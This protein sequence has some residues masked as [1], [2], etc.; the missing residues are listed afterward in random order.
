MRV[1]R[2]DS[3][4]APAA[5]P[6]VRLNAD[7]QTAGVRAIGAAA[8]QLGEAGD[9]FGKIAAQ[10]QDREDADL[11]FRAQT[12]YGEAT[13]QFDTEAMAA[14]GQN[15]WGI[16]DKAKTAYDEASRKAGEIL[17]TPRQQRIFNHW[18]G[19]QQANSYDRLARHEAEQRRVSLED[20]TKA[21]LVVEIDAAVASNGDANA[22]GTA[23]DSVGKKIQVLGDLNGW[24][25][26]RREVEAGVLLSTMHGKI[27]DRLAD[28][29]PELAKKY[30]ADN[31]KEIR[32]DQLAA[33]EKTLRQ[34]G[35]SSVA[36]RFVDEAEKSGLGEAAALAKAHKEYEG[37]QEKAAVAEVEHRYQKRRQLREQSEQDAGD[38]V[39]RAVNDGMTVDDPRLASLVAKA[40]PK[41]IAGLRAGDA[42]TN[43]GV[44]ADLREKAKAGRLTLTEVRSNFGGLGD[45]ERKELIKMLTKTPDEL[46]RVRSTDSQIA[47][48]LRD[49]GITGDPAKN[50]EDEIRK[51]VDVEQ[52]RVG[53]ELN[54]E[55]VQGVIDY[56]LIHNDD[57]WPSRFYQIPEAERAE[58]EPEDY[59]SV[60]LADRGEITTQFEE[61]RG[62]KPTP[63]EITV[64]YKRKHG[65]K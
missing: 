57:F 29:N 22:V 51:A 13:R 18:L 65:V 21:S 49:A 37:E 6:T 59:G 63:G 12:A 52:T 38:K 23:R 30:F 62:R 64:I 46:A 31:V 7:Q 14:R 28:T 4:V 50:A 61:L 2:Y 41:F 9:N 43:W 16:K 5:A 15:A 33:A 24:D 58:E 10:M 47:R 53:S 19:Q 8:E 25:S 56:M 45:T 11:A 32:G 1:P 48:N 27:I 34:S 17:K 44:Y 26:K 40:D 36:Q 42:K 3:Q 60:P 54:S 35:L 39:Q 55:Q 20:S